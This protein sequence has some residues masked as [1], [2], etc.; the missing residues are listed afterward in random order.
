M[1][2]ESTLPAAPPFIFLTKDV[3][4]LNTIRCLLNSK[5]RYAIHDAHDIPGWN[6]PAHESQT[7]CLL[8]H[9]YLIHHYHDYDKM[10]F[11]TAPVTPYYFMKAYIEREIHPY[12]VIKI[13]EGV[14]HHHSVDAV[15]DFLIAADALNNPPHDLAL[16]VCSFLAKD[17]DFLVTVPKDATKHEPETAPPA[18]HKNNDGSAELSF[19]LKRDGRSTTITKYTM[20]IAPDYTVTINH[21]ELQ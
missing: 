1:G 4:M 20:H 6:A 11:T 2:R 16:M 3:P 18:F 19:T 8:L 12:F 15:R 13:G 14:I 7:A 9:E 5:C 10:V 17:T 21:S